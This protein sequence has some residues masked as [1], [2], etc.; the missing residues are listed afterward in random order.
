MLC[1]ARVPVGLVYFTD[2]TRVRSYNPAAQTVTTIAGQ[3]PSG[4]VTD[5][6]ANTT[7]FSQLRVRDDC[8]ASARLLMASVAP[9]DC[10]P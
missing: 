2:G 9:C 3:N 7:T 8:P 5:G 10:L 6:P 4:S 1:Y